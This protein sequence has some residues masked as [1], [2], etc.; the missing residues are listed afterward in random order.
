MRVRVCHAVRTVKRRTAEPEHGVAQTASCSDHKLNGDEQGL[1]CGGSCARPCRVDRLNGEHVHAQRPR[2]ST[3]HL[4]HSQSSTKPAA[5]EPGTT[6]TWHAPQPSA[7]EVQSGARLLECLG[8]P[9]QAALTPPRPAPPHLVYARPQAQCATAVRTPTCRTRGI[10][11]LTSPATFTAAGSLAIAARGWAAGTAR[12]RPPRR[13]AA[14]G[15]A[16]YPA[17]LS[18]CPLRSA[19]PRYPRLSLLLPQD[20]VPRRRRGGQPAR[21]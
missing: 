15:A 5:S 10:T 3:G 20:M 6:H 21:H 18:A 19:A 9:A 4:G 12:C 11:P 7:P 16:L 1:D 13:Q 17:R 14:R 8:P 2:G